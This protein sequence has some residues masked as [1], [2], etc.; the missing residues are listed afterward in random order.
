MEDVVYVIFTNMGIKDILNMTLVCKMF[1]KVSKS[2]ML[3]KKKVDKVIIFKCN[4]LDA[5][6]FNYGLDKVGKWNG[7]DKGKLYMMDKLDLWY[8]KLTIIPTELGNLNNLRYLY[9]HYNQLTIIPTQLT[10]KFNLQIKLK[11]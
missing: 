1:Y 5:F 6:K 2:N 4:W 3:W 9:L 10:N 11:S 7:Y 8:K